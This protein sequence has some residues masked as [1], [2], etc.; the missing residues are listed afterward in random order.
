MSTYTTGK[1]G[2]KMEGK[3]SI[4]VTG[5]TQELGTMTMPVMIMTTTIDEKYGH[6]EKLTRLR[7]VKYDLFNLKNMQNIMANYSRI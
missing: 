3:V 4:L 2:R 6:I 7:S 5:T 1:S